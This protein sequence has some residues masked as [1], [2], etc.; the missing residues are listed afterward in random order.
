MFFALCLNFTRNDDTA[1]SSFAVRC[2]FV[3]TDVPQLEAQ[4]HFIRLSIR[5]STGIRRYKYF[6]LSAGSLL[7]PTFIG[8]TCSRG[9]AVAFSLIFGTV[10]VHTIYIIT[11]NWTLAANTI[12][13]N[14][15][16]CS[17]ELVN[18]IYQGPLLSIR[19]I[20]LSST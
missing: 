8:L 1:K 20:G 10:A 3:I 13:P 4:P 18:G 9:P 5:L 6:V 11:P 7:T 14:G 16:P 12:V 15:Y 2:R 19:E 17:T